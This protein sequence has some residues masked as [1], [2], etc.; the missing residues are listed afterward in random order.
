MKIRFRS[1]TILLCG[2]THDYRRTLSI[3]QRKSNIDN[4]DIL[5]LGDGG[6]GF[7]GKEQD[8]IWLQRISNEAKKRNIIF[9]C[10]RGNHTNPDVWDRKYQFTNL[11]LVPDYSEAIFPNNKTALIVG[12]GISIDRFYRKVGVDYWPNEITH[13]QKINKQ[14]DYLFSHDAPDNFNHS[15]QSLWNSPYKQLLL[16]DS[17]LFN[18][19]KIQ[20]NVIGQIV[21]DI[22]CKIM[23]SGHFH[24]SIKEE[25]NGIKYKCLDIEEI[26]EFISI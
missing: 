24:N 10:I 15:T 7:F 16:D 23:Y 4:F 12:G 2:D 26:S 14:F 21:E 6:E 22:K 17:K 18:D 25:K 20:R 5:F 1:N 13:Y 8:A 11:I 9:Y 19:A 3:I